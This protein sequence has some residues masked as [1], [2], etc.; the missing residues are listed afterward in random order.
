MSEQVTLNYEKIEWTYHRSDQSNDRDTFNFNFKTAGSKDAADEFDPEFS[1]GEENTETDI[2]MEEV[3][4]A[5]EHIERPHD[6][7]V[8][9]FDD[10]FA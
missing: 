5:H 7:D 1:A 4:I 6:T 3:I 9:I 10:F 8:R 2:A